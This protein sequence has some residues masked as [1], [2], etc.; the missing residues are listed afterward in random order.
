MQGVGAEEQEQEAERQPLA[1]GQRD[2]FELRRRSPCSSATS[3]RSRTA[4]AVALELLDQ[5]LRHRLAQVGAPVQQRHQRAA[6]RQPDR[7]LAGRVAAADDADPRA[8]PQSW[9]SS[10]PAA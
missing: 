5:V 10:G 2:G 6:A 9:P 4:T 7:G 1:V 8:L 3:E